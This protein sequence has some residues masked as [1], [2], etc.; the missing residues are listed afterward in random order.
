[1]LDV[2]LFYSKNCVTFV[3]DS[4]TALTFCISQWE[5]RDVFFLNISWWV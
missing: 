5:L 3:F 2:F 1:M 4:E